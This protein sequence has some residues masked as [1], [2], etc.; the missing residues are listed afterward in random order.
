LGKQRLSDGGK[1]RSDRPLE[2]IEKLRADIFQA[3]LTGK[4]GRS[5]RM[6]A[7]KEKYTS[8]GKIKL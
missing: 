8:G 2:E 1:G 4:T 6:N 3:I 5:K 7:I